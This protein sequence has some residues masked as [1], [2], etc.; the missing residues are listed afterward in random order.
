MQKKS[1]AADNYRATNLQHFLHQ[2]LG[3]FSCGF[4]ISSTLWIRTTSTLSMICNAN[5]QNNDKYVTQCT[6]KQGPNVWMAKWIW[7][8]F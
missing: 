8:D 1:T 3:F 5:I 2:W 4:K 6:L 7:Q